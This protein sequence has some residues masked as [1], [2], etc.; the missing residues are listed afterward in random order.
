MR[1]SVDLVIK[2]RRNGIDGFKDVKIDFISNRIIKDFNE[3]NGVVQDVLSKSLR[4]NE[5]ALK[6]KNTDDKRK[7]AELLSEKEEIEKQVKEL[8][9]SDFFEKRLQLIFKIL[10][11]NQCQDQDLLNPN[12][13]DE[14]VDPPEII[15]FIN[16]AISK[17]D[18][19]SKKKSLE[20]K[21]YFTKIG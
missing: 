5:I 4:L 11:Q 19:N 13:W 3:I 9:K 20:R 6:I 12:F 1:S 15:D 18:T 21:K 7:K 16:S 17:D 14:F 2:Y 10:S 8:G